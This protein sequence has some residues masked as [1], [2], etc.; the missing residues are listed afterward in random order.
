ML[1][2]PKYGPCVICGVN[3]SAHST[4]SPS[5][6]PPTEDFELITSNLSPRDKSADSSSPLEPSQAWRDWL[7]QVSALHDQLAWDCHVLA[8]ALTELA[9]VLFAC[10]RI[11]C[12]L[13]IQQ[14]VLEIAA[15]A[16]SVAIVIGRA[17][18]PVNELMDLLAA[19]DTTSRAL[20]DTINSPWPALQRL[21]FDRLNYLCCHIDGYLAKHVASTGHQ[22]QRPAS[23]D[24]L[25]AESP[26]AF[27]VFSL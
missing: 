13:E 18:E 17:I 12:P 23:D 27:G 24:E 19:P 25:M 16:D 26:Q 9:F 14:S 6:S 5:S 22:L 21:D 4:D 8:T 20:C 10:R 1:P 11:S 3:S 15:A 2:K 7:S